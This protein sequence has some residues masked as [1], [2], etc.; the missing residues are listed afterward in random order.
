MIYYVISSR[1]I[2]WILRVN[3]AHSGAQGLVINGTALY[4]IL[5]EPSPAKRETAEPCG[6]SLSV[7][8]AGWC[9]TSHELELCL[10][11]CSWHFQVWWGVL[12]F[13]TACCS[14]F[15]EQSCSLWQKWCNLIFVFGSIVPSFMMWHANTIKHLVLLIYGD[16]LF[17]NIFHMGESFLENSHIYTCFSSRFLQ[18]IQEHASLEILLQPASPKTSK[19]V[20]LYNHPSW[21]ILEWKRVWTNPKTLPFSLISS[22]SVSSRMTIHCNQERMNLI[23]ACQGFWS[24]A[25]ASFRHGGLQLLLRTLARL[26]AKAA[27]LALSGWVSILFGQKSVDFAWHV[28][29]IACRLSPAQKAGIVELIRKEVPGWFSGPRRASVDN[30]FIQGY[31][32]N[33]WLNI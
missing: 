21:N 25:S 20:Q 18:Q 15:S 32:G 1:Y 31:D 19:D 7:K 16:F 9:A 14:P 30:R 10:L 26:V 5:D 11:A 3:A 4:A 12:F 28:Q 2:A 24:F 13:G 6:T 8:W 27:Q 22:C 23:K 33:V 29:V 17:F